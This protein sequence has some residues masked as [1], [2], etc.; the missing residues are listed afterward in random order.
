M[1]VVFVTPYGFNPRLRNFVEYIIARLLAKHHYHVTAFAKPESNE[2]AYIYSDGI[3]IYKP[4]SF[5]Y[6]AVRLLTHL[7][8]QRPDVVHVFNLRNNHLGILAAL[9][10]RILR[11]PLLTTEYGLLHDHY[12]TTD[13]EDPLPYEEKTNWGGP[14]LSFWKIFRT[15][16]W[17]SNLKNYLF[18]IPLVLA[19][20]IIFVSQHN[21]DIAKRLGLTHSQY[22][23]YLF[24]EKIWK[25]DTDKDNPQG[26][27][28]QRIEKYKDKK[29]ILF[30]G[31]L[32]LRKGWD[33]ILEALP[34]INPS[35]ASH[36]IFITGSS[37]TEIPEITQKIERLGLRDRIVFFG[38]VENEIM[39][40]AYEISSIIVVPSRYEGFG[41]S[42]IEAWAIQKP[43]VASDVIAINEHVINGVNGLLVPPKDPQALALA[44]I[45]VLQDQKLHTTLIQGG[46]TAFQQLTSPEIQQQWLDLYS[47]YK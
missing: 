24:D 38:R 7:I 42:T 26:M 16:H 5:I 41:L 40:R 29:C 8:F 1:K 18:H 20:K 9:T 31:Q 13:R 12:L 10:A 27:S 33:I 35:I 4:K 45:Q 22:L 6:G 25:L 15:I 2:S 28:Q 14:I 30:V 17:I 19:D 11:I 39:K 36:L 32:K 37:E 23:P 43:V 3:H 46:S 21:L 44:I 47:Q 34:H